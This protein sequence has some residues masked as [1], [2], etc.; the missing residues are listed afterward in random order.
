LS[1]EKEYIKC[2]NQILAEYQ[3]IKNQF[4]IDDKII[5][6]HI[7]TFSQ[8]ILISVV[9]LIEHALVQ[10]TEIVALK[11]RLLYLIVEC[12]QNI[13]YHSNKLPEEHHLAY[14]IIKKNDLGYTLYSS[15]TLETKNI[16]ELTIKLDDF[17]SVKQDVISKL[18]S[19]TIQTP[20]FNERGHGGIGLLSMVEKSGK[21]FKYNIAKIS[22][23]YSL[24][25]IEIQL[26]YKN[27]K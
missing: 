8:D 17:L 13:I 10:N 12:I 4:S 19:K 27:F 3:S 7:G 24:F 11:K 1:K 16:D 25:Y 6:Q 26:N 14:I 20:T 9:S 22:S 2:E 18:F 5:C 15:N 23:N 21:N